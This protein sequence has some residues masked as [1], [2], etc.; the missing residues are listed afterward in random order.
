MK[1]L[2]SFLF[3]YYCLPGS[4]AAQIIADVSANPGTSN[5]VPLATA[6]YAANESIYTEA[7]LGGPSEFT[8]ASTA[9]T[10]IKFSTNTIGGNTVFSTVKIYFKNVS[11]TNSTFSNGNYNTAG[12]TLVF[13]GSITLPSTGWK[14]ITLNSAFIRVGGT[15]L[16]MLVT[17]TDNSNHTGFTWN[18]AMGN[19]TNANINTSRRYSGNTALSA[20]TVL[21][22]SLF[23]PAVQFIHRYNNDAKISAIYTLGKLPKPNGLPHTIKASISNEGK[24]NLTNLVVTLSISGANT[25]SSTVTI[26]FLAALNNTTISFAPFSA[27][28]SGNNTVTVSIAADDD[29]ANNMKT[30]TQLVNSNTWS[31]A[32]GTVANGGLGFNNTTGDIAAKFN[33]T[34]AADIYEI[35]ANFFTG[36]HIYK[37][38]IWDATGPGGAPGTNIWTSGTL[39]SVTG[40]NTIPVSPVTH[41]L[42]GAFYVGVMQTGNTN[43]AFSYQQPENVRT[44]T[45]YYTSPSGSNN[46]TDLAPNNP[47]RLMIEPKTLSD[48]L[49]IKIDYFSGAALGNNHILNWLLNCN[50]GESAAMTIEQGADGI[51]F[52][53]IYSTIE[54]AV[55]C[56][57]P[58]TFKNAALLP[59]KNYY[60]LKCT[61][62]NNKI[63]YSNIVVVNNTGDKALLLAINPNPVTS[64][65][66]K[67]KIVSPE[68]EACTIKIIDGYGQI[69]VTKMVSLSKGINNF[70]ID[71]KNLSAG[72]YR[73][74][75]VSANNMP[76]LVPFFKTR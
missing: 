14:E 74:A 73:V 48:I 38:G 45:F 54:T 28:Y 76:L 17:R 37:I 12:Y 53:S 30:M 66:L 47:F 60:R 75:A 20:A 51:N 29:N 34:S 23:R 35:S 8:T 68:N 70:S 50:E 27:T 6:R 58:F 15:N 4:A 42:P 16:Q 7:E 72:N 19:N 57:Q 65:T 26:P 41:I 31:Y 62:S 43:I 59:G 64:N 52:K 3:F 33:T 21:S 10:A 71:L 5:F 32:Y 55:R 40:V 25:F 1:F 69:I 2:Y 9:I 36:G 18:A 44:N 56:P 49:P 24:N 63:T 13:S 11:L 22:A 46:W 61:N 39:S 67:L